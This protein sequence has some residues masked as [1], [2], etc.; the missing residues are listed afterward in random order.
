MIR[1]I[2]SVVFMIITH[3]KVSK[4]DSMICDGVKCKITSIN[5]VEPFGSDFKIIGRC[6]QIESDKEKGE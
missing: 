6:K 1:L 4:G 2:K 3:K 5:S